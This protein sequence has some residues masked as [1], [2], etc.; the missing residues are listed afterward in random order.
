MLMQFLLQAS[1][2]PEPS[3]STYCRATIAGQ[4]MIAG[5]LRELIE[6]MFFGE[7]VEIQVQPT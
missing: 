7:D 1:P 2:L 5:G 4:K 3:L 6:K